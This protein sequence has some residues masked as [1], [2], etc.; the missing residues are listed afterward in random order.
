MIIIGNH[1]FENNPLGINPS[2]VFMGTVHNGA[3]IQENVYG[4]TEQQ[5]IELAMELKN[6]K[7]DFT[8]L[9]IYGPCGDNLNRE[10]I[11]YKRL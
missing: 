4:L 3:G 9:H 8:I 10:Y 6:I 11:G 7:K 2:L 1:I 5:V